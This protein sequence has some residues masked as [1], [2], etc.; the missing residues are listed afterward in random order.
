MSAGW[1][2][3]AGGLIGGFL[4]GW[5]S[6]LLARFDARANARV[7]A[8][9]VSDELKS[10]MGLLMFLKDR[11]VWG[12]LSLRSDLV[13]HETWNE[14]RSALGHIVLRYVGTEGYLTVANAYDAL[15][16]LTDRARGESREADLT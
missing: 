11:P 3:L 1:F 12:T 7:A 15:L 13:K 9:L 14:N 4:N 2:G 10:S 5:V 16:T 6:W 8:L